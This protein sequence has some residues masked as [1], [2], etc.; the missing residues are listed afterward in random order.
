MYSEDV[1]VLR[2]KVAQ[3]ERRLQPAIR[4]LLEARALTSQKLEQYTNARGERDLLAAQLQDRV[5]K[6]PGDGVADL[7]TKVCDAERRAVSMVG[8]L[9]RISHIIISA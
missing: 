6:G 8:P 7:L 4:A 2:G 9:Y 5:K 3:V 1:V